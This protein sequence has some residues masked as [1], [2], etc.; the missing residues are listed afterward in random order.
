MRTR[1]LAEWLGVSWFEVSDKM[2]S[3][4]MQQ[5]AI[6]TRL[7]AYMDV[8]REAQNQYNTHKMQQAKVRKP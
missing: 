2:T 7:F 1:Q 3:D 4:D 8:H 6:L 5:K